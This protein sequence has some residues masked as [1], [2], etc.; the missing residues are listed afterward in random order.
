MSVGERFV[1]SF[2]TKVEL[3]AEVLARPGTTVVAR[4]D[5]AGSGAAVC[6]WADKR[7][8]IW[9]DPAVVDLVIG[10]ADD[11]V[12][13]SPEQFEAGAEGVGLHRWAAADFRV[14]SGP[15]SPPAPL[16]AG[17][18]QRW[19]RSDRPA[20]VSLVK[21]FVDRS[22]PVEVEAAAFENMDDYEDIA[23][24]VVVP[25][26]R[27]GDPVEGQSAVACASATE[28]NWDPA[29][30]DIGV[31]VDPAHRGS[32]LGRFVVASTV[33]RL[34]ADGRLPLYRHERNNA[35][36]KRIALGVGFETVT[37]L[38]YYATTPRP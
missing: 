14:L 32:G 7:A 20:D 18:R 2:A 11:H 6:Y 34:V 15:A 19:L 36:S 28:W 16:P 37:E 31:L 21:R 5:R 35:G 27:A 30:A 17:Y 9:A 38:T 8:V 33:A 1:R 29:F 24:N 25:A 3:D 12:T 23:I 13:I 22:D 4:D 26:G 10:L